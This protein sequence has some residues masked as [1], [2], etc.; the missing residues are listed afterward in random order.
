MQTNSIVKL[1]SMCALGVDINWE[2][3]QLETT[4]TPKRLSIYGNTRDALKELGEYELEIGGSDG[5]SD[6]E[7]EEEK[8]ADIINNIVNTDKALMLFSREEEI[9][10]GAIKPSLSFKYLDENQDI[11]SNE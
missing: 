5:D 10:F 1:L 11:F 4:L 2:G 6:S 7:D 3:R 9:L 8:G